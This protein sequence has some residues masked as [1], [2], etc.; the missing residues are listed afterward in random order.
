[1]KPLDPFI[2]AEVEHLVEKHPH[3]IISIFDQNGVY[4]YASPSHLEAMG[5]SE[6]ELEGKN[7]SEFTS[8]EDA[9]R[10]RRVFKD[11]A[12]HKHSAE[13]TIPVKTKSGAPHR[14]EGF[15][16]QMLDSDTDNVYFLTRSQSV[17]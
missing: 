11:A 12:E 1:M 9:E 8:P 2:L 15:A 4:C 7:I 10:I 14:L 3:E 6:E 5:Y 13:V 17:K 16:Y